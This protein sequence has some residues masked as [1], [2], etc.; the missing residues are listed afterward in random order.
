MAAA[1]CGGSR[2]AACL[3]CAAMPLRRYCPHAAVALAPDCTC[4]PSSLQA[5]RASRRARRPAAAAVQCPAVQPWPA[6]RLAAL[7]RCKRGRRQRR[8][9]PLYARS[10]RPTFPPHPLQ[11]TMFF[12]DPSGNALEFKVRRGRP[13]AWL[14]TAGVREP[15]PAAAGRP[16]RTAL[17]G[18][19]RWQRGGRCCTPRVSLAGSAACLP[20]RP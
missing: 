17:A 14:A 5:S 7:P 4:S 19:A 20:C 13:P 3:P 12:L 10:P 11:W 8:P 6:A 15:G 9:N 18:G 1:G 2:R 16:A